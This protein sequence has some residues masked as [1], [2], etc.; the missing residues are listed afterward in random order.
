MET[1]IAVFVYAFIFY[2]LTIPRVA[3]VSD[4]YSDL[5]EHFIINANPQ[6]IPANYG[7]LYNLCGTYMPNHGKNM[8]HSIR[9]P[10][11]LHLGSIL[12]LVCGDVHPCPGPNYKFPCGVCHKPVKVNQKGILCDLCNLWHHIKCINM[13]PAEYFRLAENE[14][15]P[16]EC[17]DCQF[18]YRFTDSFFNSTVGSDILSNMSILSNTSANSLQD[19]DLFPEFHKLRQK[20]PREFI[21]SHININ[22]I[23]YKYGELSILLQN[24]L[25]D[26]LF[27][28]E[29]KLNDSHLD[30]AFK[31]DGYTMYRKD[32][33]SDGGGG[34]LCYIRSDIPSYCVK[35]Q[36][37]PIEVLQINCVIK[38]VKWSLLGVYK[39]HQSPSQ[40]SPRT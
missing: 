36:C 14:E 40:L 32:N 9:V 20:F 23:Q 1:T 11:Y 5:P 19:K 21:I 38:K 10:L 31:A 37:G 27:I 18:P 17:P 34:L 28:S 4:T 29:S 6:H 15:E 22:S 16:W 35:P 39:S 30:A 33:P 25:V 13:P 8:T 3:D 7:L 12:L 24:R 2:M 26:C